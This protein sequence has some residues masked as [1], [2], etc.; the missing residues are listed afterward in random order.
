MAFDSSDRHPCQSGFRSPSRSWKRSLRYRRR[1]PRD[2]GE[3]RYRAAGSTRHGWVRRCLRRG[4]RPPWHRTAVEQ[5][6]PLPER[7]PV[8]ARRPPNR[9]AR[10]L[11]RPMCER[12][13]PERAAVIWFRSRHGSP[14]RL[15]ALRQ[16]RTSCFQS[17]FNFRDPTAAGP[18]A[19]FPWVVPLPRACVDHAPLCAA[20]G[21]CVPVP[22]EMHGQPCSGHHDRRAV[23]NR[24]LCQN[25]EGQDQPDGDIPDWQ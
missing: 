1:P 8:A 18:N 20:L 19:T 2:A 10:S 16:H 17:R 21:K 6:T 13:Q 7:V 3:S 11:S 9:E 14:R 23:D 15:R 4:R 12:L 25:Q 5:R 22:G 24:I